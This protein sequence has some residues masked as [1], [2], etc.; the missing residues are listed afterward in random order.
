MASKFYSETQYFSKPSTNLFFLSIRVRNSEALAFFND[1]SNVG[2][3][4]CPDNFK[5]G[6]R[7]YFYLTYIT[8]VN[9]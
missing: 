2:S 5:R 9:K 8:W 1:S 6:I 7:I 3:L 4:L